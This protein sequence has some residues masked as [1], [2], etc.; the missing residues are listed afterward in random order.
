MKSETQSIELNAF[1]KP[2]SLPRRP[3]IPGTTS[4]QRPN[5]TASRDTESEN[6]R[7][8]R[9]IDPQIVCPKCRT[10]IKLTESLAEPLV[11]EARRQFEQQLAK[12]EVEFGERE[13]KLRDAQDELAQATEA[14]DKKVTAKLAVEH[15]KVAE[16]EARRARAA[17]AAEMAS[18]D[19]QISPCQGSA[20]RRLLP[21]FDQARTAEARLRSRRPCSNHSCSPHRA[22]STFLTAEG[23]F[24][25]PMARRL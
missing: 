21:L 25:N 8:P 1:I 10:E 24:R 16:A 5:T 9:M 20:L 22:A 14:L 23:V 6:A 3:R 2:G 17:V 12:K 13:A 4:T 15:S 11:A 19:R 18:R 7:A